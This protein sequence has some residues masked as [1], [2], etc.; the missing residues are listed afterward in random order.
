MPS[1]IQVLARYAES[2]TSSSPSSAELPVAAVLTRKGKGKALLCSVH[3]EYPLNDPPARDAITKLAVPP[4]TDE[5]AHSEKA[6]TDWAREILEM[7]GLKPPDRRRGDSPGSGSV[8]QVTE[9]DTSLLL[10]PTH[11]SP[12]FVLH[13]PSLPQ[14]GSISFA[15]TTLKDRLTTDSAW[16]TLRDDNDELRIGE[17]SAVRAVPATATEEDVTHFLAERRLNP[18]VSQIRVDMLSLDSS[19]TVN[20]P[21]QPPD[22]HSAPKTVLLPSESLVYSPRW[23]PL[24]NFETYWWELDLAR[25]QSGRKSGVIRG[26]DSDGRERTALGDL[27]W[28]GETV[29][30]TQTMLDRSAISPL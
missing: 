4:R 28:Y 8:P 9:S 25:Q 1:S 23:T 13:H 19:S 6:R 2:P 30:S 12:I 15:S 17:T 11:P 14:L 3:F 27:V 22:F 20:D 16:G 24:F 5:V 26:K 21:L 10:H 7:L 18:P 29:T